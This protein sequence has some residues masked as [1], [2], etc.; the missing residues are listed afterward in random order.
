MNNFI[1]FA[2]E[3]PL[4]PQEN[5][6]ELMRLFPNGEQVFAVI[7]RY[8]DLLLME[9]RTDY[10]PGDILNLILPFLILHHISEN[11]IANLASKATLINGAE[12]LVSSLQVSGWKVFCIT[13][14]YE[15]YALHLTHKLGIFAH[16]LAYTPL[17]WDRLA[18]TLDNE[19]ADLL[20]QTEA[21]V[22]TLKPT[23]DDDRIKQYLD[24]FYRTELPKTNL[25][26]VVAE[27]KPV[28][29]RRKLDAL[30]RFGEKYQQPLSNWVVVGDSMSDVRMLA[31]VEAAGGLAIAFNATEHV[32]PY[33]TVGLATPSLSPLAKVLESWHKGR[34]RQVEN[35]V[36]QEERPGGSEDRGYLHWLSGRKDLAEITEL[37]RKMRRQAQEEAAKS[38]G[39]SG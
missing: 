23:A 30:N 11:D 8:H 12:K 33:A 26:T 34:R 3:G 27:V 9:E 29:G 25:G 36:S 16:N 19:E 17:P 35:T 21:T 39:T 28:G 31:A 15:Q 1:C 4:S 38:T 6:P 18:A 20:R 10:E 22:L 5:T 7:S 24:A 13:T 2:L 32:L 14:T 37:H